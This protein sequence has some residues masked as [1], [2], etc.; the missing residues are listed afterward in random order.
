MKFDSELKKGN[1]LLSECPNCQ[2]IVWPPSE[3]CDN[4]LREV[5]WQKSSGI[6]TILEFS[7]HDDQFF[8]VAEIDNSLRLMGKI[9]SGTP[10]IGKKVTITDCKIDEQNYVV[11][12][13]VLD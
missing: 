11:S 5:N 1:F 3:Y 13:K 9:V 7:K 6:G 10:D 4:C 2:K 8:C 12:L